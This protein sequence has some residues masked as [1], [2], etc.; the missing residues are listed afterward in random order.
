MDS[1]RPHVLVVT[2]HQDLALFLQEGLLYGGFWVSVVAS[3][4]QTL[5]VLR[6]RGFDLIIVD[7]GLASLGADELIRRLR[8]R[9]D[10]PVVLIDEANRTS[11]AGAIRA[12]S[13]I[14]P[15]IDLEDV[16]PLLH[17]TVA[18]WRQAHPD[19]LTADE[20]AQQAPLAGARERRDRG[21]P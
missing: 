4:I 10:V 7:G 14:R 9:T 11:G 21:K 16:V 18:Q 19:R 8:R 3:A 15:P 20:S 1:F 2:D 17:E 13:V 6:L 5:E 12:L